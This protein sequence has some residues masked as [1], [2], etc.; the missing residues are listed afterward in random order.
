MVQVTKP[1]VKMDFQTGGML[2]R[3]FLLMKTLTFI[4]SV[5]ILFQSNQILLAE[6]II[7]LFNNIKQN[8]T[9]GK[10][11]YEFYNSNNSIYL[12]EDW[13]VLENNETFSSV[14]NCNFLGML[15]L[16][17]KFDSFLADHINSYGN[18][19]KGRVNYLSSTIVTEL[20]KIMSN[21]VLKEI[22]FEVKEA[23]YFRLI[24][25][26]TPDIS[27]VDQLSVMLHYVNKDDPVERFLTFIEIYNHTSQHLQDTIIK[28]LESVEILLMYCRGQSYDNASNRR[29]NSFV[30]SE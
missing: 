16:L 12:N 9:I 14:H 10:K 20:I 15:K 21:R 18:K 11:S 26:S 29:T 25:D 13:L 30:L 27:H 3:D 2:P 1:Y 19:G 23:K 7:V 22:V 4:E 17:G 5:C 28:F 24:V 8:V 6:L